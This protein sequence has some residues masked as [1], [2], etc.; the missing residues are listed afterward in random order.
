MSVRPIQ[1]P[2]EKLAAPKQVGR[3]DG[4]NAMWDPRF[5]PEFYGVGPGGVGTNRGIG[6]TRG[7]RSGVYPGVGQCLPKKTPA[8]PRDLRA[9]SIGA[10]R[11][12]GD[13]NDGLLHSTR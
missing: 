1:E 12:C 2:S 9:F 5:F 7:A 8:G 6:G 10:N 3:A 13:L 11:S 4:K